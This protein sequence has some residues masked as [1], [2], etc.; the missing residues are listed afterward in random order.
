MEQL[1]EARTTPEEDDDHTNP[2]IE[3]VMTQLA[4][5]EGQAS[6]ELLD[7]LLHICADVNIPTPKT[8]EQLVSA[9]S[10]STGLPEDKVWSRLAYCEVDVAA[11]VELPRQEIK[12]DRSLILMTFAIAVVLGGFGFITF[13]GIMIGIGIIQVALYLG[14]AK[15]REAEYQRMLDDE[16]E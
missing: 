4:I 14:R 7:A 8:P 16:E 6:D 3:S 12:E 10:T 15:Q 5:A 2:M 9:L 11:D 1:E 13:S